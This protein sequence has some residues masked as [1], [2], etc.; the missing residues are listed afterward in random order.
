MK[1][2]VIDVHNLSFSYSNN[3]QVLKGVSLAVERGERLG[4]IGPNGAGK[5][6]LL[7][8][9]NGLYRG[10]GR[11]DILGME[12]CKDNLKPIRAKVGLVFQ[13]PNDQLFMPTVRDDIAFGLL[14]KKV[15][16]EKID[17]KMR[18]VLQYMNLEGY[19]ELSSSQLSLGEMKR[20]ALATVL[21]MEPEILVF[22]EPSASLDPGQRRSLIGVLKDL[23]QTMV[24]ATHDLEMVLELCDRA[25]LLYDGKVRAEGPC[26]EIL[27]DQK[28]LEK[29]SLEVPASL[30][31]GRAVP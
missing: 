4:I 2:H 6:T 13:D 8:H 18:G 24:I 25:L 28:L 12:V 7:F 1:T 9:L 22:D 14:N 20:V 16:R 21:V 29:C 30:R 5:S 10:E 19:E 17:E 26:G 27:T 15:P 3:K 31:L 11:V 23:R